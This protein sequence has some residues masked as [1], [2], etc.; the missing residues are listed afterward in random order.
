[1]ERRPWRVNQGIGKSVEALFG[2]R[3]PC[4]EKDLSKQEKLMQRFDSVI[5]ISKGRLYAIIAKAIRSYFADEQVE[6]VDICVRNLD[7]DVTIWCE[8]HGALSS[9]RDTKFNVRVTTDQEKDDLY[10]AV[11]AVFEKDEQDE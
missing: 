9:N 7:A 6:V 8:D 3:Q 10:G 1:L 5:P 2:G 11:V 4:G